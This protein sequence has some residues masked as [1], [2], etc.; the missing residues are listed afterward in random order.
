MIKVCEKDLK[1]EG[2][3]LRTARIDGEKYTFPDDPEKMIAGLRTCGSRVDLFTFLQRPPE[4][5]AKYSYAM[6]WDNLAVLPLST[7]DHWWNKQIPSIARNRARQAEKR[8]VIIREVPFDEALLRGI[9]EIHN[10]TPIR[11]GRRFPHY[12]MDIEG[13]HRYAG[14]F[15]DRSFFIGAL[16]EDKLIGFV[17]LTIDDSRTHACAVNILAMLKHRDKAPTNAMIAQAVRSCADRG[18][19]Y[20]VYE[21]FTYGKKKSDSLSRFKE[22]NGFRQMDLP[23]YYVPLTP[24]GKMALNMGCHRRLIDYCP[25]NLMAKLREYRT[26]WYDHRFQTAADSSARD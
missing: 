5:T 9:V 18:L 2:R 14:T 3:G 17:K 11:Q 6:E 4:T 25:E 7:Y 1:I 15:L 24:L 13:A 12:G 8:G 26:W 20:L 19:S 23:R 16:L 21:H 10:E 22:V